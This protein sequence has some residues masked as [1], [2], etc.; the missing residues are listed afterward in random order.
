MLNVLPFNLY[1]NIKRFGKKFIRLEAEKQKRLPPLQKKQTN[2]RETEV[3]ILRY[4]QKILVE[5][6]KVE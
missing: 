3:G 6:K 4:S 5:Q 1:I 2:C